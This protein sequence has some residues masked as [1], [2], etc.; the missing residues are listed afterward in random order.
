MPAVTDPTASAYC[1]GVDPD[2]WAPGNLLGTWLCGVSQ[3]VGTGAVQLN[4]A[5]QHG[6]DVLGGVAE[7][8]T[9]AADP[10]NLA[11][12]AFGGVIGLATAGAV[13]VGVGL[14]AALAADQVFAGGAGTKILFGRAVA[15]RR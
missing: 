5:A 14:V 2:S 7:D 11:G 8:V 6:Q 4:D 15:A 12:A 1:Q 13:A 10:G 3:V 9:E